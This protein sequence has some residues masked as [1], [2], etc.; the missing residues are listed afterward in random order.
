MDTYGMIWEIDGH[1]FRKLPAI[2]APKARHFHHRR[3]TGESP[4]PPRRPSLRQRPPAQQGR[5][6]PWPTTR[7]V[8]RQ[9]P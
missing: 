4:S 2:G 1:I 5:P 8:E 9:R 7:P 6:W 3:G